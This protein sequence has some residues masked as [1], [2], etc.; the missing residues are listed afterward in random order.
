MEIN[1]PEELEELTKID[2][3]E[4]NNNNEDNLPDWL[5]ETVQDDSKKK[6]TTKKTTRTSKKTT[7]KEENHNFSK[8]S[9]LEE[10]KPKNSKEDELWDDGMKIPD[11]LKTSDD[12]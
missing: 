11:W 5:S 2:I 8:F 12:K 3:S 1:S 9:S 4:D 6:T 10:D 7:K